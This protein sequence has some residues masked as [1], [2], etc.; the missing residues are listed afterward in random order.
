MAIFLYTLA[1]FALGA[2]LAVFSYL[3]RI[4]RELGRVTT[5]R[6]HANLDIFEAEIEPRL[7]MDRWRGALTF[8]LLAHLWLVV[9]AVDTARGFGFGRLQRLVLI[10]LPS[11]APYIATGLRLA[12]SVALILAVTSE[13]VVGVPGLGRA[14]NVAASGG[15]F[16]LM[17]ALIAVAGLLG[18][19]MNALFS[20][21]EGWALRWHTAQRSEAA[22]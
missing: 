9:V 12:S 14:I 15:D 4:Y 7:G 5:G 21:L 22:A 10:V 8:S 18:L 16:P 1:V 17:Y 13:L 19:S 11:S 2:G 6:V 3:D 20:R